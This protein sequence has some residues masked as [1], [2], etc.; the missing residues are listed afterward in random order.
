MFDAPARTELEEMLGYERFILRS[1]NDAIRQSCGVCGPPTI[2]IHD[3]GPD[4]ICLKI[5]DTIGDTGAGITRQMSP[6]IFATAYKLLD[7]V[8]E[9]TIRENGLKCPYQFAQKV[10]II[11]GTPSPVYPDFIGADTALR[12]V[13]MALFKTALPY[14]NA[15]IHNRWGKNVGGDLHFDFHKN[16]QHYT[17]ELKLD[18]ILVLAETQSLLGDLLVN[19][20]LDPYKLNTMKW[21]LDQLTLL[22]GK[23]AFGIPQPRYFR[24]VR[25]TQRLGT[26]PVIIDLARVRSVV[27]QQATQASVMYDLIVEVDSA[28]GLDAWEIPSADL[29]SEDSLVLDAQWESY[30]VTR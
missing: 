10:A 2:I 5:G 11:D 27:G 28:G 1:C 8:V 22:H 6:L 16:D 19:P 29:P 7:M 18:T 30:R 20:P 9:W 15:I 17:L 26:A 3:E 12:D 25:K 24:I 4:E 21:L 23:P 14:R 13:L